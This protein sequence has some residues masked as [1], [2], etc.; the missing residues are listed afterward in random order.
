[1]REKY[2]FI[3]K[4]IKV[5]VFDLFKAPMGWYR[6]DILKKKLKEDEFFKS[7]FSKKEVKFI[8]GIQSLLNSKEVLK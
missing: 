6:I 7:K 1:M 4:Q 3:G 2:V 5:K 8:F